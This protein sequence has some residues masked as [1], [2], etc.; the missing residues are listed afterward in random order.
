MSLG[1]HNDKGTRVHV[2]TQPG[3][4]WS[5]NPTVYQVLGLGPS[6]SSGSLFFQVPHLVSRVLTWNALLLNLI[7]FSI[8][9]MQK[10]L[11]SNLQGNLVTS[12]VSSWWISQSGSWHLSPETAMR[13]AD[14]QYAFL[15][16][17]WDLPYLPLHLRFNSRFY[18]NCL[19]IPVEFSIFLHLWHLCYGR[20]VLGLCF[21]FIKPTKAPLPERTR[22]H[23]F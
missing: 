4:W 8:S 19:L 6:Y 23:K 2:H 18:L 13:G 11:Q 1:W 7:M 16:G 21:M 14:A 10:P 20:S 3:V 17:L 9:L 12:I 22:S 5:Q 15:T